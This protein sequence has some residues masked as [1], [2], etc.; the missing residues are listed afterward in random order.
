[1]SADFFKI[2]KGITLKSQSA[3]PSSPVDGDFLYNGTT[4]KFRFRQNGSWVEIGSGNAESAL[5]LSLLQ[6]NNMEEVGFTSFNS[7]EDD[8][9]RSADSQNVT[10]DSANGRYSAS[11]AGD[12]TYWDGYRDPT[13]GAS[14]EQWTSDGTATGQ[15]VANSGGEFTITDASVSGRRA[16]TKSIASLTG[17]GDCLLE[18]KM[19]ISSET[20]YVTYTSPDVWTGIGFR[21]QDG[22][23]DI[24]ANFI[25]QGSSSGDRQLVFGN[26]GSAILNDA[27]TGA[28]LRISVDYSSYHVYQFYKQGTNLLIYID[29]QYKG[30]VATGGFSASAT[31]NVTWGGYATDGG[32][33]VS[34]WQ[35]VNVKSWKSILAT[36]NLNYRGTGA[37]EGDGDPTASTSSGTNLA[38]G[39]NFFLED[40]WVQWTADVTASAP[41]TVVFGSSN[42]STSVTP[43]SARRIVLSGAQRANYTKTVFSSEVV[44]DASVSLQADVYFEAINFL[45][46][47]SC[48]IL[49][50]RVFNKDL[51]LIAKRS[52]GLASNVLEV[53]IADSTNTSFLTTNVTGS[54]AF[55]TV[56]E[57]HTFELRRINNKRFQFL[58]D[59]KV[60]QEIAVSDAN[61]T[62]TTAN[63]IFWGNISNL[64]ASSSMTWQWGH[65]RYSV[66]PDSLLPRSA[67]KEF[68]SLV[69]YSDTS[70]HVSFSSDYVTWTP[71]VPVSDT[72]ASDFVSITAQ[73]AAGYVF[74]RFLFNAGGSTPYLNNF[75]VLFNSAAG[76][77]GLSNS[78]VKTFTTAE[79]PSAPANSVWNHGLGL[80]EDEVMVFGGTEYL[81]K[82]L[83]WSYNS[84]DSITIINAHP[85]VPYSIRR[86]GFTFDRSEENASNI[87]ELQSDPWIAGTRNLAFVKSG[88]TVKAIGKDGNDL[89]PSNPA[90]VTVQSRYSPGKLITF[91]VQK[92]H[93]FID[94][95]GASDIVGEEFGTKAGTA[96]TPVRPFYIYVINTDDSENG[97]YFALSPNPTR[98]NLPTSS[99]LISLKGTP[100]A[101][102]TDFNF[103]VWATTSEIT[104]SALTQMPC[105][106]IGG[107]RMVKST[108]DD[109]TVQ[110]FSA[111]IDGIRENPY[112]GRTWDWLAGQAVGTQ[113][114]SFFVVAN[115]P[116]WATPANIR[117][118]YI[119]YNNG[120]VLYHFDTF[121]AGNAT[122]G[123]G[124]VLT[125]LALPYSN[126]SDVYETNGEP[127]FFAGRIITGATQGQ[128]LVSKE[129]TNTWGLR[130][131]NFGQ[132]QN[133]AFSNTVD[134]IF[135]THLL[136]QTFDE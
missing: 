3:D 125:T 20:T 30:R 88:G 94:D 98:K 71:P 100:G 111:G 85:G 127:T 29:G 131:S 81:V 42:I 84:E 46:L 8:L 16:Y 114:N 23:R 70:M 65:V 133:T 129:N 55:V 36:K 79:I 27:D 66:G 2:D 62:A 101:S 56:G 112:D 10:L 14:S 135:I 77:A 95:D 87:S 1:M 54:S 105:H 11:Q 51:R 109:W 24:R 37:Y 26:A 45:A 17:N 74:S 60:Q 78:L 22:S 106:R 103:F 35:Y 132:V 13:A 21:I 120:K 31:T 90:Y 123:S 107:L 110:T 38:S 6:S 61:L 89:S 43:Q 121:T 80:A 86:V 58:F 57:R 126:H 102:A 5:L 116:T 92:T 15:S 48:S 118:K 63:D 9:V 28:G 39:N 115:A 104:A 93:S 97:I 50:M 119:T 69:D 82:D 124:A 91:K 122:N 32:Q 72:G 128:L 7:G 96:W 47:D 49:I 64:N 117:A 53:G 19:K 67:H 83:D 76:A 40:N 136:V 18:V 113:T 59:G 33:S 99:S 68:I 44:D 108:S 4:N 41:T 134:D 52:T 73:R 75:A 25:R 130:T 12:F 34:V